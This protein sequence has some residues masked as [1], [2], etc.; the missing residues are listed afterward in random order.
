[1]AIYN[2]SLPFLYKHY[3]FSNQCYYVL[4]IFV[5]VLR[6]IESLEI[7]ITPTG[8]GFSFDDL[9]TLEDHCSEI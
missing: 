9:Q 5:V 3:Q 4:K 7:Y 6:L 1:M 8:K 2:E